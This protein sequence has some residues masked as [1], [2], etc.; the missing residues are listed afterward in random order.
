MPCFH[1]I[2]AWR[3]RE[4]NKSGKRSL[5]FDERYGLATQPVTVPCNNCIGCRIDRSQQWATRIMHENKYH[6]VSC[7]L[8]LTYDDYHLPE[9]GTLVKKHMQD[10]LKRLR[11][12][13]G[14]KIRYFLCGEY[15]D[16]SCRAHY[17]AIIF[18][19]DFAD[20]R[21]HSKAASGEQLYASATLDK[22]WGKGH[23]LIGSVTHQSAAYVAR[24]I[25]KKITGERAEEHYARVNEAT[26]EWYSLLPE[27]INMSTRPGIGLDYFK[28]F[29]TDMYPSDFEIVKGRKVKI[30]K[31]YDRKLEEDSPALIKK[32]KNR[33]K[34]RAKL[35]AANNTPERLAVRKQCLISKTSQLK[36]T[37]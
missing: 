14:T 30:P 8:T 4:I 27:Y 16:S 6:E 28:Q 36:R 11:K 24:Y 20:K 10:F 23:C 1:P 21:C 25:M 35:D 22:L 29:R 34:R 13:H 15:G 12:K 18:G 19:C 7:F 26:G 32:L 9:G 31:Y 17:H 2:K 3:S 37:L 5:V 33:R